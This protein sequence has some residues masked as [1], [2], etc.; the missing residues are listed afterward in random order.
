MI[1]QLMSLVLRCHHCIVIAISSS[2]EA[3]DAGFATI[4][5]FDNRDKDIAGELE[6]AYSYPLYTSCFH[7]M[8][9]TLVEGGDISNTFAHH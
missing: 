4:R 1:S 8:H 3:A 5:L 9:E 2:Q 6:A 7:R